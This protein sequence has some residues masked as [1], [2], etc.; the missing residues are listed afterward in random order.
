MGGLCSAFCLVDVAFACR[1]I[2]LAVVVLI[3]LWF[4][5]DVISFGV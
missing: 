4:L 3:V 1:L 2:V 5:Y